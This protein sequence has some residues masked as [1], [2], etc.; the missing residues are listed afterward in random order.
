MLSTKNEEKQSSAIFHICHV[1][2]MDA[3]ENFTQTARRKSRNYWILC[4]FWEKSYPGTNLEWSKE[5]FRRHKLAPRPQ[6]LWNKSVL[7][8]HD[9]IT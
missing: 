3:E 6:I 4:D 1:N 9:R 2:K 5:G 8:D 7:L